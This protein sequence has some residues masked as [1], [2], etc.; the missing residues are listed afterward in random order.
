MH[1]AVRQL[2]WTLVDTVENLVMVAPMHKFAATLFCVFVC[3]LSTNA[4]GQW[5]RVIDVSTSTTCQDAADIAFDQASSTLFAVRGNSVFQFTSDARLVNVFKVDDDAA[6]DFSGIAGL[7]NGN[8]LL[9]CAKQRR[10]YEITAG[11]QTIATKSLAEPVEPRG[12]TY[13]ADPS[14]VCVLDSADDTI[15]EYS[16][17]VEPKAI[18]KI[19][20][21]DARALEVPRPSVFWILDGK[22][23]KIFSY[24]A[25]KDRAE[26][27]DL[28]QICN[29]EGASGLALDRSRGILYV[30]FAKSQRIVGVN[31]AKARD[32][33]P[34]ESLTRLPT[35][36]SEAPSAASVMEIPSPYPASTI[37]VKPPN[38]PTIYVL[39][40][41]V[42]GDPLGQPT[43]GGHAGASAYMP[44]PVYMY[45]DAHCRGGPGFGPPDLTISDLEITSLTGDRITFRY[46]VQN[47]SAAP[48]G[49]DGVIARAVVSADHVRNYGDKLVSYFAFHGKA[50]GPRQSRYVTSTGVVPHG[51]S[52]R[53]FLIV[54]L[55]SADRVAESNEGN[56][57]AVTLLTLAR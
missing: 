27:M 51:F 7:P 34:A 23:Q 16:T 6:A 19:G 52:G 26:L 5:E 12:V 35:A 15:K 3:A 28:K 44:S 30:C 2:V 25:G 40:I 32:Y 50:L 31:V 22:Q 21:S 42:R 37:V 1:R 43:I 29:Y 14:R 57:T 53:P 49:L 4:H 55:D 39:P 33:Q 24:S 13:S 45:P 46:L 10:I 8:L 20:L 18:H 54:E 48:V 17:A 36:T 56:N 47:I 38:P 9:A 41:I 11:G